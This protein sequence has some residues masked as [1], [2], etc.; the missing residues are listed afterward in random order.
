[1]RKKAFYQTASLISIA[2]FGIAQ[3]T[4]SSQ[5]VFSHSV[6]VKDGE[7]SSSFVF[8]ETIEG[9]VTE[10][11]VEMERVLTLREQAG[12]VYGK[13]EQ[14]ESSE[15]AITENH[16]AEILET[17]KA[18]Q[19]IANAK[20]NQLNTYY[21]Q[22]LLEVKDDESALDIY[23][24]IEKNTLTATDLMDSMVKAL[25]EIEEM[26]NRTKVMIVAMI[27]AEAAALE[28]EM[29][30]EI[31]KKAL[32]GLASSNQSAEDILAKYGPDFDLDSFQGLTE[33]LTKTETD[34]QKALEDAESYLNELKAY[35]DGTK[36][37]ASSDVLE[38]AKANYEKVQKEIE[39]L[40]E[41]MENTKTTNTEVQT[42][43][44]QEKQR[45]IEEAQRIEQERLK[46]EEEAKRAQQELEN[47][48][49]PTAGD[50]TANPQ[51]PVDGEKPNPENPP[52]E[53]KPNPDN[54]IPGGGGAQTPD[55][56][57]VEGNQPNPEDP[58]VE[59]EQPTPETP[60]VGEEQPDP[61]KPPITGEEPNPESPP[62]N[63]EDPKN[64]TPPVNG[65]NPGENAPPVDREE[66]GQND[67]TDGDD[68]PNQPGRPND[69]DSN[70]NNQDDNGSPD[71]PADD[72][73]K[74]AD[75][76]TPAI[77]DENPNQEPAQ[78]NSNTVPEATKEDN[79][80]G[81]QTNTD[82]QTD[83]EEV[84][85]EEV[86]SNHDESDQAME[87]TVSR[88]ENSENNSSKNDTELIGQL[89]SASETIDRNIVASLNTTRMDPE[90][91]SFESPVLNRRED[92]EQDDL[93]SGTPE[94][95]SPD[96]QRDIITMDNNHKVK[97]NI[98]TYFWS[99]W[100]NK[101]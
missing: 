11:K 53:E 101:L 10:I 97:I 60:P 8:P 81:E 7:I 78:D 89:T 71:N 90:F 93:F 24:V 58:P 83:A 15:Q 34:L 62:T 37:V 57:P 99:K 79:T 91:S 84:Q 65:E 66:P 77:K 35:V 20:M 21:A 74:T 12:I 95:I 38:E 3:V 86:P 43:I 26:A 25:K 56:P 13:L 42:K 32:E 6:M 49:S 17:A 76:Q 69:D 27:E 52:T 33:E 14:A 80:D 63:G 44:E 46:Q 72:D 19:E 87:A 4:P 50:G 2:A 98:R 55:A 96:V 75:E 85:N 92:D 59:G 16:L 36:E 73:G 70:S 61:N 5:A 18:S 100:N 31:A 29:I 39:S 45:Q 67:Q 82:E 1:M 68:I 51:P 47:Q 9:L 23:K 40:K 28:K 64:E 94:I 48:S 30:A 41:T 22:A 88:N 54:P